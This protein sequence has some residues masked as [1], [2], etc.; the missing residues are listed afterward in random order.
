MRCGF[1]KMIGTRLGH[2]EITSHL[3]S[4]GMGDVYQATDTKLGRSTAIKLLPEAFARDA[5]RVARFD[6]EARILASLNHPHIAAIYGLEE[7]GTRKFLVME[8]VGGETLAARI[9]RGPVPMNEALGLAKQIAEALE[10]AHEKGVMHRDLKP[11]NIKVT[12]DGQVKVLDFGLA[13]AFEGDAGQADLSNSPTMSMAATNAGVIF[14][15]AAYMSPEQAKG[16]TN[17]DKRTDIFAFGAVLYEMLTGRQAFAG[18]TVQEILARVMEREPDWS[19]LPSNL[20]PQIRQLL[21]RCL[22]KDL[23][24]RRRD[25]GD[26]RVEIEQALAESGV[27]VSVAPAGPSQ[28]SARFAWSVA[29]LAVIA[30]GVLAVLHFRAAPIESAETRVDIIAPVTSDPSAFAIS[31]DGRRLIFAGADNDVVRLWLRPLDSTTAQPLAGTEG[32]TFPFW[33]PDSKSVGFFADGKLKRIDIGGGL[34]LTL[35]ATGTSRGGTWSSDGVIVF[36]PTSAGAL[37]RVAASGGEAVA[38]TK[39]VPPQENHWY[40]DF[41]P[42]GHQFL[43]Y[44]EGP[45]DVAGIYRGSIDSQDIKRV[46]AAD[47]AGFLTPDGWL[48]YLR[49]GTLVARRFDPA[50]GDVSGDPVVV[51]ASVPTNSAGVGTGRKGGVFRVGHRP[52]CVQ[53]RSRQ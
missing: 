13:K 2:Y 35:A 18:E 31:P 43:F 22:E 26:V 28:R 14:G 20:S 4:G 10:T 7:S 53:D 40:P 8:L 3:G 29:A 39:L 5:E 44:I 15:T 23:K 19:L 37:F 49:Q 27:R 38:V 45:P 51:A 21:R 11:A 25:M 30:A 33:S 47:T 17:L 41:I 42:G 50:S 46:T 9:A 16:R 6:R 1:P 48:L 52:H 32:A 36:A 12:P 24:T 34:P